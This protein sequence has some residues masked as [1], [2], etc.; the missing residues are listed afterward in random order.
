MSKGDKTAAILERI[1][2]LREV[3]ELK[4]D[5]LCDRIDEVHKIFGDH[6]KKDSDRYD[7]V[8]GRIGDLETKVAV[9]KKGLAMVTSVIATAITLFV[10]ALWNKIIGNH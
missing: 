3:V 6:E 9:Q 7:A 5:N 8:M 1:D 10:T 2:G 4:T